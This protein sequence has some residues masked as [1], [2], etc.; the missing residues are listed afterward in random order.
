MIL[1]PELLDLEE[2]VKMD[3]G[4]KM[5][6][7]SDWSGRGSRSRDSSTSMSRSDKRE[8][9]DELNAMIQTLAKEVATMGEDAEKVAKRVDMVEEGVG[10]TK[11]LLQKTN[12]RV[13]RVEGAIKEHAKKI[14]QMEEELANSAGT[15]SAERMTRRR[16]AMENEVRGHERGHWSPSFMSLNGWVDWDKKMK[17]MMDSMAARK[18]VEGTIPNLPTHRRAVIDEEVT[19]SDLSER[20]HHLKILIKSSQNVMDGMF[21]PFRVSVHGTS[22][23]H[24]H[25]TTSCARRGSV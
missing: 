9:Y 16:I 21:G 6:G 1:A 22:T 17:T 19:Y 15:G 11:N 2:N 10:A 18:M 5:D 20:V 12:S 4:R 3:L 23:S 8:E 25:G 13:E 24:L 14:Q 7:S